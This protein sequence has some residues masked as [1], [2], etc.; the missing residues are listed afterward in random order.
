MYVERKDIVPVFALQDTSFDA[1]IHNISTAQEIKL[2]SPLLPTYPSPLIVVSGSD[3]T[4]LVL[5]PFS[6]GKVSGKFRAEGSDNADG[7]QMTVSLMPVT[8]AGEPPD[9]GLLGLLQ[10]GGSG[11]VKEDGTFEIND[12]APGNYQVAVFSPSEKYR[13]WYLESLLFAGREAADTGFGATGE[14]SLEV[15]VSAKGASIEGKVVDG[16]GKPAVGVFM[17]TLP[18]SGKLGRPDSYQTTRRMPKEVFSCEV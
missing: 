10:Q 18:S 8:E 1:P 14:M 13:D 16:E 11:A 2:P 17:L 6:Y 15:V 12:V 9:K 7:K 5:P 4:D 3:L